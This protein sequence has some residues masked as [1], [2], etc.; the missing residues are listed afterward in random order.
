M[1]WFE[2]MRQSGVQKVNNFC[3]DFLTKKFL[4]FQVFSSL[5]F[6]SISSDFLLRWGIEEKTLFSPPIFSIFSILF[7]QFFSILP[8]SA[9]KAHLRIFEKNIF[10]IFSIFPQFFSDFRIWEKNEEFEKSGKLRIVFP[11]FWNPNQDL[12]VCLTDIQDI[13]VSSRNLFWFF[14]NV[15]PGWGQSRKNNR[16]KTQTRGIEGEREMGRDMAEGGR[17]RGAGREIDRERK[18]EQGRKKRR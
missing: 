2:S 10:S 16:G 8:L 1:P 18:R 17:G 14:F 13:G 11:I 6:C 9:D 4:P 3:S 12:C 15:H 7:S 5:C